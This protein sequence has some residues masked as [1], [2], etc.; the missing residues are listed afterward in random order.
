[1]KN[2]KGFSATLLIASLTTLF[3]LSLVFGLWAFSG[4]QDFKNNSDKKATAAAAAAKAQQSASDKATYDALA[5]QPY[6]SYSGS[7]TYGT[8]AFS[9]PKTWSA[10]VDQTDQ[11]EPINAYFFPGE[12]PGVQSGVA[13]PL[14]VELTTTDYAQTI[15]QYAAQVGDGS[16]KSA[17]YIPPKMASIKNVQPGVRFDGGLWQQSDGTTQKGSLVVMKVRDKT[18]LIYCQSVDSLSDFNSII[19]PSLTFVP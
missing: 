11:N 5:K 14:R 2:Q 13:F 17:A 12:V 7:A 16:I 18:L 4:R 6:K 19:L 3:V 10:Y 1:M 15:Q 8:V 9:Y